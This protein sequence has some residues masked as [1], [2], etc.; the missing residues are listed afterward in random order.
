MRLARVVGQPQPAKLQKEANEWGKV[1]PLKKTYHLPD[2]YAP[3]NLQ[4][5]WKILS[6]NAQTSPEEHECERYDILHLPLI[7]L[8]LQ[9]LKFSLD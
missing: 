1:D 7:F 6:G 3:S 8:G 5:C 2:N 4:F 9:L